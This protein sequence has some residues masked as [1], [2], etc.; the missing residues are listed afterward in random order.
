MVQAININNRELGNN[1]KSNQSH[2]LM[3]F[4]YWRSI[5]KFIGYGVALIESYI[6][7]IL[8]TLEDF[9]IN[10]SD[11]KVECKISCR[12]GY[13]VEDTDRNCF[14]KNKNNL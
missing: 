7:K 5:R 10:L 1:S 2:C 14:S 8:L 4:R 12:L 3:E 11:W 13:T 9:Q 6:G